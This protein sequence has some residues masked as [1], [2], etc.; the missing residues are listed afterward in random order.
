MK[1]ILSLLLVLC[2]GLALS[3]CGT[4]PEVTPTASPTTTPGGT[5]TPETTPSPTPSELDIFAMKG[6]TGIGMAP[7]FSDAKS[8]KTFDKYNFTIATNAQE[9][10]SDLIA[11]NYDIA[12]IPTNLAATLA[13]RAPG[14]YKILAV[15]TLGV[16]YVLDS[17]GEVKSVKD[18]KGKEIYATGSGQVPQFALEYVL[19]KNGLK[20][21]EDVVINY[22]ADAAD[23]GALISGKQATVAMLPQPYVTTVTAANPDYKVALDI[24]EEWSKVAEEGSSLMTSCIVV[25]AQTYEKDKAAVERF[26]ETFRKSVKFVNEDPGAASLTVVEAGIVAKAELAEKAIPKC[27]IVCIEGDEMK[28]SLKAF[29][30]AIFAVN[31]QL[32]GG[33][34]PADEIFIA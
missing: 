18:L 13:K 7:I 6:P 12:S 2:I 33:Q 10:L 15:N 14:M 11:G 3:A 4:T 32:I 16:L 25:N 34:V 8:G 26:M 21:G 31:P 23:V 17:S 9:K 30:N 28:T 20:P 5:S 22:L 27:N 24:T 19:E 29:Y 1:K